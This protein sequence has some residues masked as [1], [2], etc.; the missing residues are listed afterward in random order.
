MNKKLSIKTTED[1]FKIRNLLQQISHISYTF[2]DVNK[3]YPIETLTEEQGQDIIGV[4]RSL[5]KD[6]ESVVASFNNLNLN[7][8]ATNTAD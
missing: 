2:A 6:A 4:Y 1:I 8:N 3:R 5:I 7:Q